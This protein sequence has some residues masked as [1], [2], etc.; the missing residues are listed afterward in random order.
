V[1]AV[2]LHH[3]PQ[4][5][6]PHGFDLLATLAVAHALLEAPDAAEISVGSMVPP[7]GV[8]VGYFSDLNAP[9]DLAE[10]QRLVRLSR[11]PESAS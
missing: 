7:G 2:A 10:A 8:D 5:I 9:F 6:P 1:E 3:T 11:S 4:A